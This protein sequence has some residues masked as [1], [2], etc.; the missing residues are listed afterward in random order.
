[1]GRWSAHPVCAALESGGEVS[2]TDWRILDHNGKQISTVPAEQFA[3]HGQAMLA[4]WDRGESF[5]PEAKVAG[6]TMPIGMAWDVRRKL[7]VEGRD[8]TLAVEPFVRELAGR[9]ADEGGMFRTALERHQVE[10]WPGL[11]RELF[12]SLYG[13]P[14]EL[15]DALL[16]EPQSDAD[17]WLRSIHAQA[18]DLE[19]WRQLRAQCQGDAWASGIGAGRVTQ[20]LGSVLDEAIRKLAPE[21][22]PE[23]L[24]EE[25]DALDEL[26][27]KGAGD[28]KRQEGVQAAEK[29]VELFEELEQ[30][31][32]ALKLRQVLR[33]AAE[34]AEGEIEEIK[35]GLRGLGVGFGPGMMAGVKAPE[36]QVRKALAAN[37]KLRRVAEV[38][39]RMRMRARTAQRSKVSYLPEQ[40]VDV[41]LGGELERL[42]PSELT[43]LAAEETELVAVRKLIERQALEYRLEGREQLDKGPVILCVDGSGSMEGARNEWAMGVALAVLELASK[44]RRPFCLVHFDGLVQK[45]FEIPARAAVSFETLVEMVSY[46]S[47]G[48]TSFEPPL[49][50]ASS[51]IAQGIWK[52]ADVL[53]VTDGAGSWGTA[54]ERLGKQGAR[55]YGV[56]I[57]CDFSDEQKREL[58][59]SARIL[60]LAAQGQK[61]NGKAQDAKVDLVFGI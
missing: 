30:D 19:E 25:A 41:T 45:T 14:A 20:L 42:L 61:Q 56:A 3:Q 21:Q 47:G 33:Q 49:L 9:E 40:I 32:N 1:M 53:L 17:A 28:E 6:V 2:V 27:G 34:E 60:N 38:A 31:E 44:Q 51:K 54:C 59:G 7:L 4:A 57:D 43:L 16:P 12:A 58:S 29:A 46:F 23:R 5:V 52:D 35:A 24:L 36:E 55:V 37:P 22:D 11:Q 15:G 26:G 13:D 10:Q 18:A 50:W 39:G 48:G 8:Q